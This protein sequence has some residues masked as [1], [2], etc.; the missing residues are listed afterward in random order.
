[1]LS[2]FERKAWEN[3]T[4]SEKHPPVMAAK[5]CVDQIERGELANIKHLVIVA[6][7]DVDGSDLIHILQAG[8][9]SQ[10]AVEGALNRAIMLQA[11]NRY[12]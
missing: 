8:D 4:S 6:V 10:L 5:A 11:T 3:R 2:E 7:Q 9:L 1:M 12:E